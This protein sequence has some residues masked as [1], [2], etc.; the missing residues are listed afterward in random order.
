MEIYAVALDY[1][2]PHAY[3]AS[4]KSAERYIKRCSLLK[5]IHNKWIDSGS[6]EP[7]EVPPRYKDLE[8]EPFYCDMDIYVEIVRD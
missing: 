4:K 6:T 3:F 8:G 7:F 1:E 2:P 5:N